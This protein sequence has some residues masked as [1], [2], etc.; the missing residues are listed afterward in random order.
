MSKRIC[1][2][3]TLFAALTAAGAAHA[4]DHIRVGTPEGTAYVFAPIDV[5]NGAGIF[6]KAGLEVEKLNFGGGAKLEQAM[7]AGAIDMSVAGNIGL[8]YAT[9]GVP[10]KAVAV[11]AGPP[12]EMSVIIRADGDIRKVE[13]LKGKPIGVGGPTSLTA[14][15]ALQLSRHE[16]WGPDGVKR[17]PVGDMSSLVAA[18]ETKNVD[19][20]VGPVEGG[21]LLQQKGQGKVLLTYGPILPEFITHGMF[22]NNTLIAQHPDTV[23]RFVHAWFDTINYM[24]THKAETIKLTE[25]VTHLPP[26]IADKVYDLETPALSTTGKFDQKALAATMQSFVDLGQ[27]DKL[28]ADTSALYTTQFLP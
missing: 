3:L 14:W 24:R 26:D 6:A 23:R 25:P 17:V 9:K 11:L 7:S 12:I 22:A 5:G 4:A 28:P 2:L 21:F 20:I 18:L 27:I 13:D 1:T 19:G 16:G 15:L 8:A 10:E